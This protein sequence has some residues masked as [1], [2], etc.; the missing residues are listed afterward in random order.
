MGSKT[1]GGSFGL[2]SDQF[3]IAVAATSFA[4]VLRASPHMSEVS[5]RQVLSIAQDA[6]RV[7]YSE[8]A[9]LV[10]LIEQAA[11]LRGEGA[12]VQR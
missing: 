2:A 5:M 6:Q 11:K 12:L 3:R 1:V 8:D 4:E 9:E 7:E 10:E